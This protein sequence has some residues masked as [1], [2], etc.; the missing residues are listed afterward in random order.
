MV[1]V[2]V[3]AHAGIAPEVENLVGGPG[4]LCTHR[5]LQEHTELLV[6]QNTTLRQV[7]S[8]ECLLQC[9]NLL[10]V[11]TDLP[12]WV[13]MFGLVLEGRFAIEHAHDFENSIP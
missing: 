12:E 1:I 11:A 6:M 13:A 2:G 9:L 10:S 3:K 4:V 7:S 5:T 8:A